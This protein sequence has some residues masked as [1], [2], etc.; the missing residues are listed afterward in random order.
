MRS[1][2]QSSE[3]ETYPQDAERFHDLPKVTCWWR[4]E[5][6]LNQVAPNRAFPQQLEESVMGSA[7]FS[8]AGGTAADKGSS[9]PLGP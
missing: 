7:G 8:S 4:A 2:Q 5:Q 3:R 1:L 9:K 6:E